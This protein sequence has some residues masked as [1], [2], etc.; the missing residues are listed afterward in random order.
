M[1]MRAVYTNEALKYKVEGHIITN[2]DSLGVRGIDVP[3]TGSLYAA[4]ENGRRSDIVRRQ[5][6]ASDLAE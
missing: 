6:T 1:Q 4:D 3:I 2:G 5:V